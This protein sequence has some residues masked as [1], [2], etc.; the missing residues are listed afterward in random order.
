VTHPA[1]S[2][3]SLDHVSSFDSLLISVDPGRRCSGQ[4]FL[5]FCS[6]QQRRLLAPAGTPSHPAEE[7][8]TTGPK[9]RRSLVTKLADPAPVVSA[10]VS[11]LSQRSRALA[12]GA[13]DER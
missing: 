2:F 3:S 5:R 9:G 10:T 8:S 6:H 7:G 12:G 1:W 13:L 4:H 11:I